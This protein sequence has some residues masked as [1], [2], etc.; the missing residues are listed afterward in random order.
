MLSK[1]ARMKLSRDEKI[2]LWHWMYDE[3]HY[4]AGPGPAK[5]L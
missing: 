5:R 2:F 1:L 4:Q 3:A